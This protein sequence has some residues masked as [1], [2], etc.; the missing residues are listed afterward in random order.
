MPT[1]ARGVP[2][3]QDESAATT[4]VPAPKSGLTE[5]F[6]KIEFPFDLVIFIAAV[7]WVAA[8]LST[9]TAYT[10]NDVGRTAIAMFAAFA[11]SAIG[12]LVGFLFG[13]PKG[14]AEPSEKSDSKRDVGNTYRP[15][16]NLEQVSDW[17]TKI[18]VGVGLIQFRQIG[19][20]I[21]DVGQ[22]V[23]RAIGDQPGLPGSGTVFA[24]GLMI[25]T[26]VVTFL[27][28]YMWTTTALFHVYSRSLRKDDKTGQ[29]GTTDTS[30][31][32]AAGQPE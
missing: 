17:L 3:S 12:G 24:I 16:T 5:W 6:K 14:P 18:I 2:M 4:R 13:V 1:A 19:N 23:G 31:D 32:T 22:T 25:A 28:A 7:I 29:R 15:N 8:A 26:A 10:G 27:L 30:R 9:V 21:S 20:V 11:A